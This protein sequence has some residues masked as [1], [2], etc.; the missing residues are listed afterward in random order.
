MVV[1]ASG[2]AYQLRVIARSNA[3][4]H[5][6]ERQAV[7]G[8]LALVQFDRHWRALLLPAGLV[9]DP[10]RA[11]AQHLFERDLLPVDDLA[12]ARVLRGAVTRRHGIAGMGQPGQAWHLQQPLGQGGQLVGR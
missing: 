1:D 7:A 3:G 10:G 11:L 9:N 12:M 6:V 2:Q 8:D 4:A 5:L